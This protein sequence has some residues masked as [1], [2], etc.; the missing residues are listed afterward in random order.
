MQVAIKI[1]FFNLNFFYG[2]LFKE[3]N[4]VSFDQNKDM[5]ML[6]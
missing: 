5:N 6:I 1:L 2:F 3:P 4:I